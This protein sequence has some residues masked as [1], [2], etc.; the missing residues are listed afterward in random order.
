MIQKEKKMIDRSFDGNTKYW[1]M[2]S[3]NFAD[4][5][6]V[7]RI[8]GMKIKTIERDDNNWKVILDIDGETIEDVVT[9]LEDGWKS[10]YGGLFNKIG[11]GPMEDL[12]DLYDLL[13][14][15]ANKGY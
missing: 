2:T 4:A 10:R 6:I 9:I 12:H 11:W 7:H 5:I 14:S 8:S 13:A 15:L 3:G 1:C